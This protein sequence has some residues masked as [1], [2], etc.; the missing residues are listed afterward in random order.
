MTIDRNSIRERRELWFAKTRENIRNFV[1][2]DG[3]GKIPQFSSPYR[4]P[5]WILPALYTGPQEYVALAN[6]MLEKYAEAPAVENPKGGE[7]S[8]VEFGIFQSNILAHCFNRFGKRVSPA[9]EKLMRLHID[10]LCR[11]FRGSAQPDFKFHGANDNMPMMATK[12]LILG[13]EA[14]GNANA[15]QQGFWNL[16]QFRNLLSRSAWASEF[17]SSTYSPITLAN[18]AMIASHSKSKEIRRLARGIEH[19]LWAELLLHYHP[20]TMHQAGP[21]CRAYAIDYAGHNHTLQMLFWLVFGPEATGRD[22]IA[23]YFDPDGTEVIHFSGCYFQTVAEFCDMLDADF[24]VP[25]KLAKLIHGRHYPAVL[26]GRSEC[27][28][29]YDGFAAQYNTE[30]YMEEDFSLGTVDG[31]LCGGEHTASLYATYKLR[32][33]VKTYRDAST[34]FFRYHTS[35]VET[36][37]LE[38]SVDGG[39]RN[40]RFISSQGWCYAMQ[41]CNKG[42]LLT[43]PNLKNS[44]LETDTLKL[45]LI[46]PAHYGGIARSI[47]GSLPARGGFSGES[48]EVVPV[49][50]EAG[51]VFVHVQPLLPTNLERKAAVRLVKQNRYEIVEM[52]NYEGPKRKFSRKELGMVLNGLIMTISSKSEWKSLDDFH[53]EMSKSLIT[54]YLMANHRFF[55]F[56]R[57]D[58]RFDVVMTLDPFGLQTE[59]VDGRHVSRPV[60]ESNQINVRSLPFMNGG[61][62]PT[63]P[64]FPWGDS[65]DICYYPEMSWIIGSRGLPEEPSYARRKEKLIVP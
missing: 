23:S 15:V 55:H 24:K 60:F 49:S 8:G 33:S 42:L 20:S 32:P 51:E 48:P 34:I 64:F 47:V 35:D 31:P 21:Q 12:G 1:N 9:A 46:F 11:T 26:R 4:E 63:F 57:K 41:K 44:P 40:E 61:A 18:C 39:Y 17:N 5:L 30:T 28:S 27:M 58:V 53:S 19:R 59:A 3:T 13:G 38:E 50:V 10:M 36:G 7:H 14:V 54:D 37:I 56:V 52:V 29:R 6:R 62:P 45:S 16:H 2:D 43:V 25:A 65:L 22:L